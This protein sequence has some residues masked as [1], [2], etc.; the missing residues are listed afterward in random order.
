[1]AKPEKG[2]ASAV[3]LNMKPEKFLEHLKNVGELH[4][5]A[6]DAA[7]AVASGYKSLKKQGMNLDAFRLVRKLVVQGN[8][9]K[10]AAFLAD[11]DRMRDLA[12]L[13]RQ[14][15]LFEEDK[16]QPQK[17]AESGKVV[18]LKPAAVEKPAD[19]QK[20]PETAKAGAEKPPKGNNKP[21]KKAR[22]PVSKKALFDDGSGNG[23]SDAEVGE[24]SDEVKARQAGMAAGAAGEDY[25]NP[26]DSGPLR[27]AWHQG[28]VDGSESASA[29]GEAQSVA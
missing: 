3:L 20:A 14:L 17:D 13:N 5:V 7:M 18:Q 24:I 29:A 8:D 1:M 4:S 22:G 11:F 26:H 28:Y 19:V 2:K 23:A 10:T 25:Q 15:A 12:G 27:D 16:A 6:D 21:E 9:A